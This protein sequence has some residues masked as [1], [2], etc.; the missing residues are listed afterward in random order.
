MCYWLTK[1]LFPPACLTTCIYGV[2]KC[3]IFSFSIYHTN[4]PV[5]HLVYFTALILLLYYSKVLL[6]N[7][8]FVLTGFS[9]SRFSQI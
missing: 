3:V 7:D 8:V 6:Y 9:N 2:S 5:E 4:K 1:V